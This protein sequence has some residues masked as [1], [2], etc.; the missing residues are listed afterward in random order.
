MVFVQNMCVSSFVALSSHYQKS[1]SYDVP[2]GH[3]HT[4]TFRTSGCKVIHV[5][6]QPKPLVSSPGSITFIPTETPYAVD[7][8]DGGH[9]YSV[10]FRLAR[11]CSAQPFVLLPRSG[12]EF[13][14]KFRLLCENYR[15]DC[16][17]DYRCLSMLYDI[18]A[19]L[20]QECG[21]AEQRSVPKRIRDVM[22]YVNRHYD[23]P[24]L[25]VNALAERAGIS[26]V[27][28]RREFRQAVGVSPGEY[29]RRVRMENAKALLGTALYSITDVA[30]RCG[31]DSISYFSC[32]FRRMYGVP[33]S[34]YRNSSEK[35]H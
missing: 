24:D 28:L 4:L 10:H 25:S 29:I 9:M 23:D 19:R 33:P 30:I 8:H 35:N 16:G 20:E 26:E 12:E 34:V 17:G 31:F 32:Q 2:A 14:N 18:F 3:V 21:E 27:Y 1:K 15:V 5:A 11:E 6:G 7:A 13:A 22:D